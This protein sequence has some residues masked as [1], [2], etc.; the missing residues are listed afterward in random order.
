MDS[1]NEFK[2]NNTDKNL[3]QDQFIVFKK[4]GIVYGVYQ[5]GCVVDEP[6]LRKAIALRIEA[7]EGIPRPI[8]VDGRDVK[9][10]SWESRK[11][12]FLP[13]ANKHVIAYAFL[14]NSSIITTIV[15]WAF[16]MFPT[17]GIPRKIFTN[18]AEAI[19][20]LQQFK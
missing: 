18:E 1:K 11:I 13:D 3:K 19:K 8:L 17:P 4:D 16:K 9:Y 12:G 5:K 10:W 14:L 20:W 6:L 2:K 7:S 15:K